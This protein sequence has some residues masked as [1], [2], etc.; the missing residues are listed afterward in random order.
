[1]SRL[2]SIRLPATLLCCWAAAACEK[3]PAPPAAEA[4]QIERAVNQAEEE[5][6]EQRALA[7]RS[8]G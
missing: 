3:P 8:G 2:S 4:N 7:N 6:G 5:A 1:M